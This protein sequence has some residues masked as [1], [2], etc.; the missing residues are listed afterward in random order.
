[1]GQI[2]WLINIYKNLFPDVG[3]LRVQFKG[4]F[5]VFLVVVFYLENPHINHLPSNGAIMKNEVH[6]FAFI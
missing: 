1:M 5:V 4:Y 6:F 3:Y 2:S